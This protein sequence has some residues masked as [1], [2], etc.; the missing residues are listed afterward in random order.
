LFLK[1]NAGIMVRNEEEL[2]ESITMLLESPQASRG[3]GERAR[4]LIQR[5]QGATLRNMG[6]I[7][8]VVAASGG[9]C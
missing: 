7:R 9:L 6:E 4:G 5:N 3:F 1:E 2:K 8:K